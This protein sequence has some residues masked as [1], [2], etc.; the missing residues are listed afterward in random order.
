MAENTISLE[1]A[2]RWATNWREKQP[3]IVKAFLIPQEDILELYKHITEGGGQDV[4][5]YLGIKDDGEYKLMLVAVDSKGNDLIDLG[6]YDMT[7]PCPDSCDIDSPLY[8]LK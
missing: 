8:T 5:G 7:K 3:D 2:Q 1:T 4:R 6:I